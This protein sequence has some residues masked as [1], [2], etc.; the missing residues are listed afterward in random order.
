MIQGIGLDIVELDRVARLDG[1]NTKFRERILSERELCVYETLSGHRK[2][3]YLAGRF[4]AKE[5]FSK[6]RGTGIGADCSFLD[7]EVM[8]EASGRPILYFHSQLVQGFISI[9]HTQTVAAAQVV[10][11]E[12]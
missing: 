3:E 9:T 11:L 5:A 6:A 8:S 4:A 7:I 2:I 10:L 12:S 1:R